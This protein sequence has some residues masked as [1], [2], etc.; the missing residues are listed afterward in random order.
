MACDNV[1]RMH[2]LEQ[3]QTQTQSL[4]SLSGEAFDVAL[5]EFILV[6]IKREK[7]REKKKEVLCFII[8]FNHRETGCHQQGHTFAVKYSN[9]M[10]ELGS[11]RSINFLAY[12]IVQNTAT[13]KYILSWP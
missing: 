4:F 6:T 10:P 7:M 13:W 12:S 3:R 11:S 5:C 9:K 8:I 1:K 2:P